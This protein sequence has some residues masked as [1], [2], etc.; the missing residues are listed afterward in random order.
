MLGALRFFLALMVAANHLWL[1]VANRIGAPAVTAFYMISGYLMSLVLA[2]IYPY[3]PKGVAA[4]LANRALRIFPVYWLATAATLIG[5]VCFPSAF[6]SIYSLI[7]VPGSAS[8][9]LSNLT[10][11]DLTN[12]PVIIVPPAWSLSVEFF[13]YIS[14][15]LALARFRWLAHVWFIVSLAIAIH[16]AVTH[17]S[18]HDRYYPA[19]AASLFFATGSLIYCH[20]A[21]LVRFAFPAALAAALVPVFAGF[22]LLVRAAGDDPLTLGYYGAAALFAPLF[23]TV[24]AHPAQGRLKRFD[25]HM[26]DLAYPVF[27]FHFFSVGVVNLLFGSW[28]TVYSLGHFLCCVAVTIALALPTV[29]YLDPLIERLRSALRGARPIEEAGSDA[30]RVASAGR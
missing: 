26:G 6:G 18:F 1:P 29:L 3:T 11:F 9:L 24:L 8:E 19:Y 14:M 28:L 12:C 13:F 7:K 5:L 15:G 22:T 25:R 23:V 30:L 2:E 27:L 4:F 21:R 17:R 16:L 20:R 10:L